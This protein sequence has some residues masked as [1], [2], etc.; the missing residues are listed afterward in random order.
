MYQCIN[1]VNQNVS[2]EINNELII[3]DN[4]HEIANWNNSKK[5]T[6]SIQYDE[7]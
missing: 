1:D 4:D 6:N 2:T 5:E 7:Q 3:T